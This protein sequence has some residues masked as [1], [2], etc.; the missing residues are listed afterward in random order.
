MALAGALGQSVSYKQW[1]SGGCPNQAFLTASVYDGTCVQVEWL[2]T[3]SIKLEQTSPCPYGQTMQVKV[4]SKV[5]E[6]FVVD[7][8]LDGNS[9][10]VDVNF[11]P[12]AIRATC[13]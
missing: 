10:C 6:E 1:L 12:Q 9:G 7:E 8:L 3:G 2:T 5:C 4:S 13:I 11:I